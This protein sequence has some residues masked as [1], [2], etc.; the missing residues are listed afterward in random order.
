MER[1]VLTSTIL[2]L[3]LEAISFF[4]AIRKNLFLHEQIINHEKSEKL[5]RERGRG[6]ATIPSET[7]KS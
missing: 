1:I 3:I 7:S 5:A 2:G 6:I 4:I